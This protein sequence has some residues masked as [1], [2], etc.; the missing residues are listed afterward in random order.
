MDLITVATFDRTFEAQLAKNLLETE[1]IL[2][3]LEGD[4]TADVLHLTNE[5][6]LQVSQENAEAARAVL[7]GA[8]R[9]ELN[10]ETAREAEEAAQAAGEAPGEPS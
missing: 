8:E 4:V 2:A 5:I 9:H 6:K 7:E 3:F 1:G 10:A